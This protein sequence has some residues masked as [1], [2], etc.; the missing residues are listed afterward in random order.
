[1]CPEL[2]FTQFFPVED[3]SSRGYVCAF[4]FGG[5]SLTFE[6]LTFADFLEKHYGLS[7]SKYPDVSLGNSLKER[8]RKSNLSLYSSFFFRRAKNVFHWCH[9]NQ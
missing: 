6:T 3:H 8:D 4:M 5:I 7:R 2:V 9:L 1:M